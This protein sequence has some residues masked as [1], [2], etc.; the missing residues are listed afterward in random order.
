M[1]GIE[2]LKNRL[3]DKVLATNN[4]KLLKAIDSIFESTDLEE[5]IRLTTEQIEMLS[6]SEIEI[7]REEVISEEQL[8]KMDEE[9]LS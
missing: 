7:E 4:K 9:W 5:K 1:K 2:T 3:I 6:M 8:D